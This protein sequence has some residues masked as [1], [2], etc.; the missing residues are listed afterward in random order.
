MRKR[1]KERIDALGIRTIQDPEVAVESLSGG[2]RQAVAVAR[3]AAFGSK[4]V[5]L[6]E[7]TAALGVRESAQVLELIRRL[8]A[9]GLGVVLISHNMP[10]VWEV[11]DRI[12]V[13]RLGRRAAVITP[14][15][16][17]MTDGVALMTGAAG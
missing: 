1:A 12:H 8:R 5:V 9:E 15:S 13:Q 16:H 4:V 11:A 17:T 7:P 2:Q 3:A 6:D 14:Q 10:H